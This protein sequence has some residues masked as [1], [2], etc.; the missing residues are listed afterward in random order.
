MLAAL[1]ALVPRPR[2]R[3]RRRA[4]AV[5]LARTAAPA[6]AAGLHWGAWERALRVG[7]EA[8]RLVRRGRRTGLLPPRVGR[9]RALRRQAGPGP[10]RAG[11]R[12]SACA[13]RSPTSAARSRAAARSPWSPTAPATRPA[14]APARSPRRAR[15]CRTR[16]TR[17][18]RRRP[19][20]SRPSSAPRAIAAEPSPAGRSGSGAVRSTGPVIPA[21]VI[22]SR[23]GG[24]GAQGPGI[25]R[26]VGGARRNLVAAGAGALLAAVLGTVVTLGATSNP[27][28]APSDKVG[29]N[30]SAS[31]G[32]DDDGLGAD[33]AD[34]GS[35]GSDSNGDPVRPPAARPTR[36]P[37]G[38]W[39]PR[40]TR[41]RLR[42][43]ARGAVGR[44]FG[45]RRRRAAG[46]HRRRRRR[47]TSPRRPT[48][49]RRRPSRRRRPP[50][51]PVA[52]AVRHVDPAH[53]RADRRR[54]PAPSTPDDP[55]HGQRPGLQP[56]PTETRE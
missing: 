56:G 40:T 5:L 20:A 15:R 55:D 17:S 31:A 8:A 26:L 12:P 36:A 39:A 37:T 11:G 24:G 51:H 22:A 49:R 21:T 19:A 50:T 28:D 10:C 30:P 7:A 32:S 43:A 46:E 16:G 1:A 42:R 6:F 27:N 53:A 44:A 45:G 9:P 23:S 13:A 34:D 35:A 47:P 41:R 14:P 2:R 48:L 52:D 33:K 38:R 4:P 25:Q 18:R 29:V 3:R 54:P